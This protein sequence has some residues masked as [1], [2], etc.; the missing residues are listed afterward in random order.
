MRTTAH[1]NVPNKRTLYVYVKHGAVWTLLALCNSFYIQHGHANY[2]Y[3]GGE[4]SG[5]EVQIA[6][7]CILLYV[8]LDIIKSRKK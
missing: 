1:T 3:N 4:H 5:F 2:T 6:L 7:I 8:S